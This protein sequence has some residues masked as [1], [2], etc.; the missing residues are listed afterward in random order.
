[1]SRIG[2]LPVEVPAGV[3]VTL[4]EGTLTVKGPK[5]T[6]SLQHHPD[7]K[8]VVDGS[9]V[10]VE[11]PSDTKNHRALHGLTRALVANMV[12]GVTEG[13]TKTL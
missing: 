1:M 5:G 2:K 8:L 3:E 4:A 13:F 9:E 6:L 12:T 10:R 11:R 7:M